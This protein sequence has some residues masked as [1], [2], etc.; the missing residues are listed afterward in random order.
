[1]IRA[2]SDDYKDKLL[3]LGFDV[4]P[5]LDE[6]IICPSSKWLDEFGVYL[7][8]R[9]PF[10]RVE[11]FDCDNFSAWASVLATESLLRAG[12][13]DADHSFVRAYFRNERPVHDIPPGGHSANVV[14]LDDDRLVLFEPQNGRWSELAPLVGDGSVVPYRVRW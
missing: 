14:W 3:G 13:K 8:R 11:S 6:H 7:F 10:Y 4:D 12:V 2:S 5:P 9:R 1:M